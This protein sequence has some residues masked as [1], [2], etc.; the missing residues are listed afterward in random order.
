MPKVLLLLRNGCQIFCYRHYCLFSSIQ[1]H[2]TFKISCMLFQCMSSVCYHA[3]NSIKKVE[4]LCSFAYIYIAVAC[5]I[6]G[7]NLH[8]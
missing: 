5:F 2:I 7:L 4:K 1:V 6:H 3:E 8:V